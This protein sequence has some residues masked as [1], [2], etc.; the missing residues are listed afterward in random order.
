MQDSNID[1]A[2]KDMSTVAEVSMHKYI[3]IDDFAKVEIRLG[4]VIEAKEVEGSDKL[5]QLTVDFGEFVHLSAEEELGL[6]G[7]D[8][9]ESGVRPEPRYRN[10]MSGIRK[11][12]KIEDLIGKQFPFITNLAPRKMMGKY[13]SEAMILAASDDAVSNNTY[14]A[15]STDLSSTFSLFPTENKLPNGTRLR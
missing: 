10:V 4:T 5:Y 9:V 13:V 8:M 15:D 7:V 11:Y 2:N 12:R 3:S 1:V 14:I 6:P